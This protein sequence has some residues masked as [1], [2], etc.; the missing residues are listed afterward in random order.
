MNEDATASRQTVRYLSVEL[1]AEGVAE[2]VDRRRAVFV[3]RV[4]I[5]AIELRRGVAAERPLVQLVLGVAF[6]VGGVGLV[7]GGAH[8]LSSG[9]VRTSARLLAA[10]GMLSVLGC[11]LL[12]SALRPQHYLFVRNRTD[13][14]KIVF[15]GKADLRAIEQALRAASER[16]GYEVTWTIPR[17]TGMGPYR[18]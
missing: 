18:G 6:L 10:A 1:S 7:V 12:Y 14:S 17:P 8:G 16:W 9:L 11:Y 5:T 4:E 13:G 15:A 2:W 3:P